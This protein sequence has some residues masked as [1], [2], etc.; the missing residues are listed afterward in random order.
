MDIHYVLYHVSRGAMYVAHYGFL[1]SHQ[2][3]EQGGFSCVC[4]SHNRHG[5]PSL[6]GIAHAERVCQLTDYVL[7]LGCQ[8]LQ[9]VSVGK[10]QFLVVRE[11]YL[12][13]QQ[14]GECKQFLAQC[15][16]L[17]AEGSLHLIHS[18]AVCCL[19]GR[20]NHICHRLCLTQINSSV[21]ECPL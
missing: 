12:Q 19:R 8:L 5:H 20:C 1:L 4:F 18:H 3:I 14:R 16:Q 17:P 6:D 7:H 2:G 13:F 10:L 9:F 15:C 21:Q 11:V